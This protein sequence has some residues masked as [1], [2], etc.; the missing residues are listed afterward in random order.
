LVAAAVLLLFAGAARAAEF[1]WGVSYGDWS[2][3]SNWSGSTT[4]PTAGD[5]AWIIN[6]G[7]AT[8]T[9][10]GATASTLTL[11]DT[12]GTGTLQL[13]AGGSLSAAD[14]YI[15][16]SG[17]GS[18]MQTGGTNT[19]S[20]L[21]SVWDNS[22]Y[23]L[24]GTGVLSAARETA[25]GLFQQTGGS[26]G[27]G[28]LSVLSSGGRYLLSGG[29]LQVSG[30]LANAGVLDGGNGAG[31]L[32][33]GAGSLV[34]FSLENFSPGSIVNAGS[35]SVTIGPGSLVIVPTSF[36]SNVFGSFS[37]GT[38]VL[39]HTAGT[40]LGIAPGQ[41]FGGSGQI[42][43]FVACQGTL[44]AAPGGLINL[45]GG[46]SVSGTG[47]VNLGLG[48]LTAGASDSAPSSIA[49][50]TVLNAGG[51]GVAGRLDVNGTL[52]VSDYAY[53]SGTLNF[54]AGA[55]GDVAT[56]RVGGGTTTLAGSQAIGTAIASGGLLSA[57][58]G[59]INSLTVSGGTATL[60]G[61]QSI[62]LLTATGGQLNLAPAALVTAATA[63]FSIGAPAVN[64]NPASGGRL[65]I[66]GQLTLPGPY[67]L[68]GAF[69]ISGSNLADNALS[70]RTVTLTGGTLGI[71]YPSALSTDV[72]GPSIPGSSS[73]N[74]ASGVWT[75]EGSG[76]D[77]FP[78]S[79]DQFSYVYKRVSN[80]QSFDV[81]ARVLSLAN[82]DGSPLNANAKIG[83]MARTSLSPTDTFAMI[84]LEPG[85]SE[86][87]LRSAPYSYATFQNGPSWTAPCYIRLT[88]SYNAA[89]GVG[90]FTGY[91]SPTG[92]TWTL[93]SSG[94]LNTMSGPFDLGLAVC[95]HDN[96]KL[97]VATLDDVTFLAPNTL[98]NLPATNIVVSQAST[99]DV[100]GASTAIL[101]NLSIA[102]PLTLSASQSATPVSFSG[103][104]AMAS[105][106]VLSEPAGNAQLAVRGGGTVD[107]A[108]GQTLT[109]G[110]PVVD[111]TS[112]TALVKTSPGTLVLTASGGY[113][114][115]V[116]VVGGVL[117]AENASA[118]PSGSLL[119]IGPDGSVVF[120][121]PGYPELGLL[122]GGGPAGP[123]ASRP[124]E[125]GGGVKAVPEP[126]TMALLAAAVA[127][128]LAAARRMKM[129]DEGGR[130]G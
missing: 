58:S 19:V 1:W 68:S 62:S 67:V 29:T 92:T 20:D 80:T 118:I 89:S 101:G 17:A 69:T 109:I 6:G 4:L 88:Y 81:T 91:T 107:V 114:G 54:N 45:N 129:K 3:P 85:S 78:Y 32:S 22:T 87:L 18:L 35:M 97:L 63:D 119:S 103:I 61:G 116:S 126:G 86:W 130:R 120:G 51:F 82:S 56:L 41:S 59:Q 13:M 52:N 44:S 112:A 26:N 76:A 106:S 10:P 50:G 34:N 15:G 33:I 104:S 57:A 102:A 111:G 14:Q 79:G 36:N 113:T 117:A 31:V 48:N 122:P 30:G 128:G 2:V 73:Y 37:L 66:T 83:I 55:G 84:D 125:N 21:V 12:A 7:T 70:P 8:V 72:G 60:A 27:V 5:D 64:T 71:A 28:Y 96:S 42:D 124:A 75:V 53:S 77:I 16:G 47:T 11:G 43:D 24:G 39:V 121:T 98:I 105:G 99:L 94:W 93:V 46:L 100:G 49:A 74:A 123:L 110:V 9:V 25:G 108:A 38:G 95:S 115:G 23:N 65:A 127:C 90:T 40:T